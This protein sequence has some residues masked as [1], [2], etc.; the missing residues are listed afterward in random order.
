MAI[1]DSMKDK[2]EDAKIVYENM[3]KRAKKATTKEELSEI[4]CDLLI[5]R[6]TYEGMLLVLEPGTGLYRSIKGIRESQKS[7]LDDIEN[8]AEKKGIDLLS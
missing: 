2:V 4:Y 8:E 5:S 3:E 6:D 7:L 1:F